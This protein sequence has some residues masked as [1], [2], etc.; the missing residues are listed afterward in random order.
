MSWDGVQKLIDVAKGGDQQAWCA[1][2]DM[3][4][5]FILEVVRRQNGRELPDRSVPDLTQQTW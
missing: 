3:A 4:R 5:L 1:L 2:H